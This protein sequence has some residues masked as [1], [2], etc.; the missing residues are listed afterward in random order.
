MHAGGR[1]PTT[2]TA[3]GLRWP[4][5]VV[6]ASVLVLVGLTGCSSDEPSAG[7]TS[8][9]AP[10]TAS[11]APPTPSPVVLRP[12]L[13]ILPPDVPAAPDVLHD[14]GRMMAYRLGPATRPNPAIE[15]ARVERSPNGQIQVQLVFAPGAAGIDMVNE[16]ASRCHARDATCPTGQ[17]ATVI[18]EI[19]ISA[20]R[21]EPDTTTFEPFERDEVTLGGGFDQG[22][23]E[24]IVARITA[25]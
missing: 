24:A 21:I 18:D 15:S 8:T 23:A 7:A 1:T 11:T 14:T 6:V 9:L 5:A 4:A 3:I 20:P 25:G 10:T 16:V 2:T 22:A 19:V 12:V 13:E 17:L